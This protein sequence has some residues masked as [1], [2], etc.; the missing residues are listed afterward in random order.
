MS[1][2]KSEYGGGY[3]RSDAKRDTGSTNRQSQEAWHDARDHASKDKDS[4]VPSDRHGSKDS[5]GKNK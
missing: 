2:R 3:S 5:G 4:R 1:K